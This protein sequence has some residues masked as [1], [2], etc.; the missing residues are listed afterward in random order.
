MIRL[1]TT[2]PLLLLVLL[3]GCDT[4]AETRR[5][6]T[7]KAAEQVQRITEQ[8]D[9]ATNEAGVYDRAAGEEI[10]ENDPWGTQIQVTYSQGGVAETVTVRSAGPDRQLHTSDDL[11]AQGA[12]VN[13]KGI[14]EGIKNNAETTAANAAKG[15][16]K[17][18]IEGVK[19]SFKDA[20]P[21]GN[22][23]GSLQTKTADEENTKPA[24]SNP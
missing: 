20:L 8:L 24:A 15:A 21:F 1:R 7:E 5:L 23:K 2:L 6:Q 19:E 18:T 4:G 11:L 14:G 22:K 3:F 16:V 13:F 9:R 17:G 12:A 10:Q